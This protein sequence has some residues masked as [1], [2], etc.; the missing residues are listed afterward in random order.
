MF[1][2]RRIRTGGDY[3]VY[4]AKL[5]R[6]QGF[7]HI[8]F[9][10]KTGDYGVDL[11]ATHGRHRYAIQCKYYTGSVGGFAVQEAVAGMAY[12][13]CQRAMVVTNSVLTKNAHAL[14]R[15]NGVDVMEQVDPDRLTFLERREPWQ[16]V[17]F[18]LEL[19]VFGLGVFRML[20]AGTFTWPVCGRWALICIPL[21]FLAVYLLRGLWE[22]IRFFRSRSR[23]DEE[24]EEPEAEEPK[25]Q[26]RLE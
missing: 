19:V 24:T 20:D 1:F 7:H 15:A 2:H 13:Q 5:L 17:L 18:A 9:T 11:L 8:E 23:P 21:P 14:A 12:Y 26:E 22:L 3:E 16:L 6:R 25:N 10:P 4:V